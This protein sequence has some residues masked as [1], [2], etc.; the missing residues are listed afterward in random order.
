MVGGRTVLEQWEINYHG[1]MFDSQRK[2]NDRGRQE[3]IIKKKGKKRE[4][5]LKK[6]E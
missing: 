5:K 6:K 1:E 2:E 3:K 4:K